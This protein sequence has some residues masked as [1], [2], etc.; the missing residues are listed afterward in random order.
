MASHRS[1]HIRG[2]YNSRILLRKCNI[3]NTSF[4]KVLHAEAVYESDNFFHLI[5][6]SHLSPVN[7]A[8]LDDPAWIE[9]VC[10]KRG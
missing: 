6:L 4:V 10:Q 7:L 1:Q 3:F 5:E 2:A 8:I 9:D